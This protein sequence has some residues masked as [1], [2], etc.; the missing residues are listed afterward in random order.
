MA[1]ESAQYISQLVASNPLSTDTVAQAD[2]HIRLIKSVLKNTFPNLTAPVTAT[3][4]LLNAPV[5]SGGIIMWSGATAPTGWKLCDGSNGTPDLRGR[6]V[7][8]ANSTYPLNTS[9]GSVVTGAAGS[10]SHTAVSAGSHVHSG[11]V[12]YTALTIAQM[13]FHNHVYG[14]AGGAAVE[15]GTGYPT[16]SGLATVTNTETWGTGGGEAHTHSIVADGGHTHTINSVSDHTHSMVPPYYA[17]AYI[18]K[19]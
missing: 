11:L 13:P 19:I 9:G 15:V 18:M 16:S 4:D 5:P 7:I 6:F 14:L 8:G 3:Q 12:G 1:L 2:D 17:L 10:H